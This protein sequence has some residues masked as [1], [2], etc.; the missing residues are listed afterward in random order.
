MF[1]RV[2]LAG[3]DMTLVVGILWSIYAVL[4]ISVQSAEQ[5]WRDRELSS[6]HTSVKPVDQVVPAYVA[7]ANVV[8]HRG[9]AIS[10]NQ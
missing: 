2:C 8:T 7:V 6:P 9:A 1:G 10:G 4:Q 5:T 3:A